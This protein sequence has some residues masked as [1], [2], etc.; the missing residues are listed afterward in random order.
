MQRL[1][2]GVNLGGW[3]SHY[4]PSDTD[5]IESFITEAD[6]QRIASWGM[7]HVR[8]PIDYVMIESD[9]AVGVPREKGYRHV[10]DCV[11]WCE[12]A[13]LALVLD[14]HSVPGYSFQ[15]ALEPNSDSYNTLF[16]TRAQQRR[17]IDLWTTIVRRYKDAPIPVFYDLLNAVIIPDPGQWNRLIVRTVD[18]MREVDPGCT[19]MV[20]GTAH[21]NSVQLHQL[22]L[23][24]DDN[25][26]FTFH[27][28]EPILFTHQGAPW[29]AE[30]RDWGGAPSY[31][32]GFDGLEEF[33]ERSPE[34]RERYGAL[35][36]RIADR[37][38]L[39]ES[40][41]PAVA[42]ARRTGRT[43]YCGDYGAVQW[44]DSD[45]RQAWVRDVIA[46]LDAAGIGHAMWNYKAL[47]FGLVDME[48]EIVDQGV[49]DIVMGRG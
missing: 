33:L 31:P 10:D 38:F 39:A 34:H 45:S 8:L 29:M 9:D 41:A 18:A 20:G 24:D 17:F 13:G 15:Y 22:E 40:L 2:N 44:A 49:L 32:G 35:V 30:V 19:V 11:K 47:C 43:V 26:M 42:F 1:K 5:R 48:G 21:Y 12:A 25:A 37:E 46:E 27:F 23:T 4:P 16:D 7:D 6:I 14:L 28:F 36:G 3:L